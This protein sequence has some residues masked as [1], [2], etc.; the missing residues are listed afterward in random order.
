MCGEE[1]L[2]YARA[3]HSENGD[4][5]RAARQQAVIM[6]IRSQVINIFSLPKLIAI[7][8]TLYDELS[9]GIKTNLPL[10]TAIKLAWA[11]KD[12]PKEKIKNEVIA[13]DMVAYG[14]VIGQDGVKQDVIKPLPD[15]IRVMR[16]DLFAND[17]GIGPSQSDLA[18]AVKAEK[19]TITLQNDT[20]DPN[21]VATTKS[22]LESQGFTVNLSNN[23]GGSAGTLMEVY[24]SKPYA[25]KFLA[26]TMRIPTGQITNK[27][28]PGAQSSFDLLV[29][30]GNDWVTNNPMPK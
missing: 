26:Q 12:V 4:F 29:M 17:G 27:M 7:A 13:A 30:I 18:A 8:P 19:A 23:T 5:D 22:Y 25:M 10:D 15:K 20:K 6:A 9:A 14:S 3:R 21:I 2:A 24:N 28:T 16:D 11:A 1:T